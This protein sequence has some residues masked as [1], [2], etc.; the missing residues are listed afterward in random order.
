MLMIAVPFGLNSLE[1]LGFGSI[2]VVSEFH[3]C[4]QSLGIHLETSS[5]FLG[6]GIVKEGN[7]LVE[8]RHDQ[9]VAQSLITLYIAKAPPDNGFEFA[10]G[11]ECLHVEQLNAARLKQCGDIA[12]TVVGRENK[13]MQ[14]RHLT[15]VQRASELGCLVFFSRAGNFS[16]LDSFEEFLLE[17]SEDLI[18]PLR[19]LALLLEIVQPERRINANEHQN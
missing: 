12:G 7:V 15:G 14:R 1:Q 18:A 6:G 13:G 19:V 16:G 4:L 2:Q 17:R 3:R 9:F 11:H 10:Q 8:I 5:Q